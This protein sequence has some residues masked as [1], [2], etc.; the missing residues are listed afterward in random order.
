MAT[1]EHKYGAA[2]PDSSQSSG[3]SKTCGLC[4]EVVEANEGETC[5]HNFVA[6]GHEGFS[7]GYGY[8][9]SMCGELGEELDSLPD[10]TCEHNFVGQYHE[11]FSSGYGEVCSKCGALG[12]ELEPPDDGGEDDNGD[13]TCEH[14]WVAQEHSGF[15]SGY[16]YIC[17]MC[18][19]LGEELEHPDDGGGGGGETEGEELLINKS[20]LIDIADAVRATTGETGAIRVSDLPQK[21]GGCVDIYIEKVLGGYY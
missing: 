21:I 2:Y 9:C 8:V 7:S 4:G 18:G 5:E 19:A 20:T 15:S 17:S 16:G 6:Q 1:C 11:G 10:D 3:Y 13:E 14:N 12:D